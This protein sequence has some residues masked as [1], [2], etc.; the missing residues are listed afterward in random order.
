M[1]CQMGP[2]GCNDKPRKECK[3]EKLKN[4]AKYRAIFTHK[5]KE[6]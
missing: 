6:D 2:N 1:G 4:E 3:N 5:R